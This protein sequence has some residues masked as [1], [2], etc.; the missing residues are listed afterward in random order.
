MIELKIIRL[1]RLRLS[2]VVVWEIGKSI[3]V[4][5]CKRKMKIKGLNDECRYLAK[6][7]QFLYKNE[8]YGRSME[9]RR[10]AE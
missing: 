3:I 6:R 7:S 1:L 9:H 5:I 10:L 4:R 2:N 8:N